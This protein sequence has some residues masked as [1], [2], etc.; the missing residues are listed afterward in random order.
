MKKYD[1]EMCVEFNASV[2]VRANSE[3]EAQVKA[4]EMVKAY[5]SNYCHDAH[6][7]EI[8]YLKELED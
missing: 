8:T 1:V 7:K 6:M 5:P 2:T 3:S 4:K